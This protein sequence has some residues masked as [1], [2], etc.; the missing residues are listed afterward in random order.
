MS[1]SVDASGK[2]HVHLKNSWVG[3]AQTTVPRTIPMTCINASLL[4]ESSGQETR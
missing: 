1:S 2:E 3:A 4:Q